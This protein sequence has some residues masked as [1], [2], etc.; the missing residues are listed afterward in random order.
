MPDWQYSAWVERSR[1]DCPSP[2]QR[3]GTHSPWS[4]SPQ[5]PLPCLPNLLADSA[6]RLPYPSRG[7]P[8]G[9]WLW[10]PWELLGRSLSAEKAP[11]GELEMLQV[12]GTPSPHCQPSKYP[13]PAPT[14]SRGL[15][16]VPSLTSLLGIG[17]RCSG[18]KPSLGLAF[19]LWMLSLGSF[20]SQGVSVHVCKVEE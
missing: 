2:G 18:A 14:W 1:R 5:H 3:V 13:S 20:L 8:S 12:G 9:S 17:P 16:Q 19:Q 10:V 7:H 6:C 4:P 11:G 15:G